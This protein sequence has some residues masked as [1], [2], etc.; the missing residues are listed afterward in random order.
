MTSVKTIVDNTI[1][2]LK[3]DATLVAVKNSW[4]KGQ[5]PE[6][7]INRYPYGWVEWL[8]GIVATDTPVIEDVKDNLLIVIV[9]MK[10]AEDKAEDSVMDY[11]EKIKAV[12]YADRTLN[13]TVKKTFLRR[14]EKQK[15]LHEDYSIAAV[16]LT[17]ELKHIDD[18]S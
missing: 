11:A 15:L 3:A 5:P 14:R 4:H 7:R 1:S 8:G 17:F 2:I 12:I 13:D 16:G 10:A 18:L 9:D 6:S